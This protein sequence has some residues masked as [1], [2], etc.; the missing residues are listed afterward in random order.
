MERSRYHKLLFTAGAI[1]NCGFAIL[2]GIISRAIPDAF[3]LFGL[4]TPTSL[5]WFD[6]FLAFIFSLG[7]GLYLVS[8]D[9]NENHGLIRMAIFWKVTV[10]SVGLL[11][12]IAGDGSLWVILIVAVD[13]LFG[14]LFAEDLVVINK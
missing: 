14:I 6:T 3:A 13:L 9:M 12:T 11:H 7:L 4:E 5:L 10:F 2:F 8:L 1:W